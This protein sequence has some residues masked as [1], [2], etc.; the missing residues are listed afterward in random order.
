MNVLETLQKL[1]NIGDRWGS[2]DWLQ[3][4]DLYPVYA[5]VFEALRP[6]SILEIGSYMGYVL[7]T[8]AM[9]VNPER[10][11]W[12]DDESAV[13][14]SNRMVFE[15]LQSIYYGGAVKWWKSIK[16]AQPTTPVDLVHCDADHDYQPTLDALEYAASLEPQWII[17][18]DV[19][20]PATP[21][22]RQ[23]VED[24]CK[25]HRKKWLLVEL[26]NGLAVISWKASHTKTAK[27]LEML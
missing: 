1:P 21:G 6:K 26:Q 17:A 27:A 4:D 7:V 14:N 10:M 8:A 22:A 19:D 25:S 18:H 24:F 12:I 3:R 15:N 20:N 9:T 16:D 13:D 11:E 5:E 23:A 2:L